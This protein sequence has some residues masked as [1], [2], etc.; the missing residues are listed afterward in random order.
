MSIH[1][2]TVSRIHRHILIYK[3]IVSIIPATVLSTFLQNAMLDYYG[4]TLKVIKRQ[5]DIGE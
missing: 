3:D 1:S 4:V 2:Y 5:R